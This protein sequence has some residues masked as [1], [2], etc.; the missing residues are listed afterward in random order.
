[1]ERRN[2]SSTAWMQVLFNPLNTKNLVLWNFKEWGQ[3]GKLCSHPYKK[4]LERAYTGLIYLSQDLT[5]ERS[6]TFNHPI[7]TLKSGFECWMIPMPLSLSFFLYI[8]LNFSL[9]FCI[10][11]ILCRSTC[12]CI[13]APSPY[14]SLSLS[15]SSY[16][17]I[18]I[19]LS[20]SLPLSSICH[21]I[22]K[23]G[24]I[25]WL[26]NIF[27]ASMIPNSVSLLLL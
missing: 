16:L 15:L 4:D 21:I 14:L 11:F 10:S 18:N 13:F 23:L 5:H 17:S 7:N 26:K 9:S 3:R 19:F 8:S 27:N 20:L 12:I 22:F 25:L 2:L 6:A 24:T 1:M